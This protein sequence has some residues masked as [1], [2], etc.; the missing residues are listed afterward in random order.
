MTKIFTGAGRMVNQVP[1]PTGRPKFIIK[2][3]PSA[4][5]KGSAAVRRVI[6]G[7]GDPITS[8]INIGVDDVVESS[9]AFKNMSHAVIQKLV[10]SPSPKKF[11]NFLEH[12]TINQV[13]QFAKS[14]TNVRFGKN[15]NGKNIGAKFN[16]ILAEALAAG[17]NI[18]VETTG[19]FKF[20]NW[21]WLEYG[22][23]LRQNKYEIYLIFPLV[24][25]QETWIRYKKRPI[26]I[27]TKNK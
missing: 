16:I 25:F 2:Y 8:Y 20:P 27:Y 21:I 15:L 13:K 9:Q 12:A 6:E 11:N 4:S 19:A 18:T 3:G 26:N 1:N 17:K 24:P 10:T 7:F 5:G 14:Y 22:E 23:V